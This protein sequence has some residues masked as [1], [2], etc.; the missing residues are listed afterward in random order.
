MG[1][2][3]CE[4]GRVPPRSPPFHPFPTTRAG[5]DLSAGDIDRA[6]RIMATG[7]VRP[8]SHMEGSGRGFACWLNG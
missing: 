8:S 4:T 6:A 3:V 5:A 7:H 1:G 2:G